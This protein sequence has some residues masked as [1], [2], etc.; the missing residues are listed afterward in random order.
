MN[1]K[2]N[3]GIHSKIIKAFIEI[4]CILSFASVIS[5]VALLFMA[6]K[7]EH[8]LE[9]SGFV[10]GDIGKAM[11]AFAEARSSL[12]GAIG[13]DTQDDVDNMV[14]VYNERKASFEEDMKE[15]KAGNTDGE[16]LAAYEDIEK[17]LEGYWELSDEIL[18]QGSV[19]DSVICA[20]AQERAT[21]EL[22]PKFDEVYNAMVKLM[23]VNVTQGDDVHEMMN[24]VKIILVVVMF[25]IIVTGILVALRIAKR[26]AGGIERPLEQL[27]ARL[28]KFAHGDLGSPFPV[29]ETHDEIESIANECISMAQNLDLII[30]DAGELLNKMAEGNFAIATNIED[31]YEGEFVV[32]KDAMR[33]LNRQLNSTLKQINDATDQVASGSTELAG[34]A[35]DLADGATEQAGA[36][37]ELTATIENVTNISDESAEN[38]EGA[39]AKAKH[40]VENANKSRADMQNLIVAMGRITDTSKEIENIIVTIEDIASQT[41]LLSLNA[42]IEAARAGDAGRGFA[43]VADQI[44]K[45]ASDS[46]QSAVTTKEL[47]EKSLEEINK[48]NQ[49]VE[50][51]MVTIGEV[52]AS[53][54]EFAEIASSAAQASRVQADM[55]EQIEGG[56]EQISTVVQSNS[57]AAEETSAISEELSAQAISLKEMIAVFELRE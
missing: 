1:N 18:L 57:A 11:T 4:I 34:S 40:S 28:Q 30:S 14:K 12:R 21:S 16:A 41:N 53:M 25:I 2:T 45:L 27:G 26:I 38:A 35:T 39:A 13:Y 31:K 32:L 44:G 36:V 43:V 22:A 37:Q 46:A 49:I 6:G 54:E 19:L 3:N 10:Q 15:I 8:T 47:I 51:T 17:A 52:L 7:Y 5:T 48:G 20:A 50:N 29:I 9:Y 42:S 23:D 33:K 24:V 55:L 56:I